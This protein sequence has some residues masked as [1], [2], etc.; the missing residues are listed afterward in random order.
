MKRFAL[1]TAIVVAAFIVSLPLTKYA[2]SSG[3][4]IN[5]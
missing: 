1:W 3:L 2:R 4:P 5:D